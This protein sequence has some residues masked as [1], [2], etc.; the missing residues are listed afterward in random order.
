MNDAIEKYRKILLENI[1]KRKKAINL[2]SK[3]FKC[4]DDEVYYKFIMGE[5]P[6]KG[7]ISDGIYFFFHGLGCSVKNDQENWS[8]SLEFGPNGEALALDEGTIRYLCYDNY[9]EDYD[10]KPDKLIGCLVENGIIR[11]AD[12]R[13]YNLTKKN[14]NL[15]DLSDK[16]TMDLSVA[17]RYIFIG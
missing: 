11:L 7:K 6:D 15:N 1:K 12:E 14:F 2:L 13:L 17:H 3:Y 5:L 4:N 9:N 10:I 8:V 16:E